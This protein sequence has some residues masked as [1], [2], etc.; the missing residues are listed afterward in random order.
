MEVR[1]QT[2]SSAETT[3]DESTKNKRK[4]VPKTVFTPAECIKKKRK[5]TPKAVTS[6]DETSCDSSDNSLS[7]PMEM[8]EYTFKKSK[9]IKTRDCFKSSEAVVSKPA[10]ESMNPKSITVIDVVTIIPADDSQ[11]LSNLKPS[12]T[13]CD[14]MISPT[15]TYLGV[16]AD[17]DECFGFDCQEYTSVSFSNAAKIGDIIELPFGTPDSE[18]ISQGAQNNV[19]STITEL[20]FNHISQLNTKVDAAITKLD[21]LNI[22]LDLVTSKQDGYKTVIVDLTSKI[23]RLEELVELKNTQKLTLSQELSIP[24]NCLESFEL[25]QTALSAK[26]TTA[27][28]L[29]TFLFIFAGFNDLRIFFNRF[30]TFARL[31]FNPNWNRS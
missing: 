8:N 1:G 9:T 3:N 18:N 22:K 10:A 23:L 11:R 19:Q 7:E 4:R 25:N 14:V 17:V 20:L 16:N 13:N 30:P 26:K 21:D 2:H 29:V 5:I 12:T 31:I 27:E 24:I 28:N 6:S 15:D